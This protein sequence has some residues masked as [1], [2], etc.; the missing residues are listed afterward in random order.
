MIDLHRIA[1]ILAGVSFVTVILLPE[2]LGF[3]IL[4]R[5]ADALNKQSTNGES[6][7]SPGDIDRGSLLETL[8]S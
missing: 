7:I 6:Y 2:T 1:F 4:R 3:K 5:K 8:V